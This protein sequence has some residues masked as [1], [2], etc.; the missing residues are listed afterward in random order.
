MK[1]FEA[2]MSFHQSYNIR[3]TQITNI[4]KKQKINFF[5]FDHD[6]PNNLGSSLQIIL[7]FW[8][9]C[10]KNWVKF[11]FN[12]FD[13][14]VVTLLLKLHVKIYVLEMQFLAPAVQKL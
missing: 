14:D 4:F 12:S 3:N 11:E 2:R 8:P 13:H 7:I 9:C 6:T 1:S 5:P 10:S